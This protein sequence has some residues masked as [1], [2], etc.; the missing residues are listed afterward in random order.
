LDDFDVAGHLGQS[1]TDDGEDRKRTSRE[2][3]EPREYYFA[4]ARGHGYK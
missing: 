1:I 4:G 3:R 2:P